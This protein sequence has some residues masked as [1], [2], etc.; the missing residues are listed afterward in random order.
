MYQQTS[1]SAL[2]TENVQI[3]P[4]LL[5]PTTTTEAQYY[6]LV[7]EYPSLLFY[8][9]TK[10]RTVRGALILKQ[11]CTSSFQFS[12]V[13]YKNAPVTSPLSFPH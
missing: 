4:A 12:L 1:S 11:T 7:Q 9:R 2:E 6:L 10:L 13:Y 3:L 5:I 8:T